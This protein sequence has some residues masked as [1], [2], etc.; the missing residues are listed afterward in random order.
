MLAY[1]LL[2]SEELRLFQETNEFHGTDLDKRDGFI[3][4]S[5]TAEQYNRVLKKYYA[6]ISPVH[7]V[8]I[9]LA[10]LDNLKFEKISNGDIYPHQYGKL[11]YD[12]DVEIVVEIVQ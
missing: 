7:L 10:Q 8:H 11:V 5:S 12:R 4:M 2:T 9:R 3:H 6:G 1:K